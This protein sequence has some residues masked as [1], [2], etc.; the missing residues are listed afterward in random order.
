[1][2]NSKSKGRMFKKSRRLRSPLE[3]ILNVVKRLRLGAFIGCGLAGALFEHPARLF[4]Q[5]LL[6]N[7]RAGSL[8][9]DC[10]RQYTE[11]H[12]KGE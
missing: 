4:S 5:P 2:P 10:V 8:Q 11:T 9:M 6:N 1:M 12:S 3:R 7:G